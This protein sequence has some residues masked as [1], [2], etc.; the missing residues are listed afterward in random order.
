MMNKEGTF[1]FVNGKQYRFMNFTP[2]PFYWYHCDELPPIMVVPSDG[3]IRLSRKT[4]VHTENVKTA[5]VQTKEGTRAF[6]PVKTSIPMMQPWNAMDIRWRSPSKEEWD[7]V[8]LL[9]SMPVAE[10]MIQH[11]RKVE[12]P[13]FIPDSGP[14]SAVRNEQGQIM[15]VKQLICYRK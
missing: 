14:A 5:F 2:H 3:T 7:Q 10:Y 8:A 9:V 12:C 1:I 13:I 6:G 11:Q 4:C 15:G